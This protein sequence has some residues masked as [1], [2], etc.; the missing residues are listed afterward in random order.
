[1]GKY[2]ERFLISI[3]ISFAISYNHDLNL[4]YLPILAQQAVKWPSPTGLS[5]GLSLEHISIR[6]EHLGI[7]EHPG[8]R[9][10]RFGG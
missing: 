9:R 1:M 3:R 8:G 7:K 5:S 2:I 10:I 4:F 6:Y